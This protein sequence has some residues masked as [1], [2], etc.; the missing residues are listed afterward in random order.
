VDTP[1][2]D[3]VLSQNTE[4]SLNWLPNVALALVAISVDS[5]LSKQDI[6]LLEAV[7]RH[8]PEVAL[9]I[10]KVD[11]LNEP[12][13]LEV[14]NYIAKEVDRA[15]RKTPP[16][17]RY[18]VRPGY[19]RLRTDIL[20][21]LLQPR[22]SCLSE[23]RTSILRHKTG[24]M[25]RECE[26]YLALALASAAKLDSERA[27]LKTAIIGEKSALDQRKAEL[28]LVANHAAAKTFE[29]TMAEME[30]FRPQV[31]RSVLEAFGHEFPRWGRMNLLN[32]TEAYEAWL[33]ST[34]TNKLEF[35]SAENRDAF[36]RPLVD[37]R[38][39][40]VR[41]LE[42]FRDHLSQRAFEVL[43]VQLRLSDIDAPITAPRAPQVSIGQ[44]F[45]HHVEL[46]W[47]LIP[48]TLFRGLTERRL[49]RRLPYEVYKNLSRLSSQWAD[50]LSGAILGAEKELE[51]H[52]DVLVD[53]LDRL[54]SQTGAESPQIEEDLR[55][56]KDFLTG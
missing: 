3:S 47:F 27:A 1:G 15:L 26:S 18:S 52:M 13:L 32:L 54:L 51:R 8:T 19:E 37:V 2:L 44:T 20:Q 7:Y 23:E 39:Q 34:L 10:T 50:R 41:S 30:R 29:I 24:A 38:S 12:E 31:E 49:Q 45:Q 46:L 14:E 36:T 6:H 11:L 48:M 35:L 42:S 53:T 40:L 25:L 4:A 22:L 28:R 55:R 21:T 5:P 43:G 17:F 33:R 56:V 16:M 9:L